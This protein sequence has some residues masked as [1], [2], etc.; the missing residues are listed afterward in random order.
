MVLFRHLSLRE[1]W[2]RHLPTRGGML[3]I[4]VFGACV[5][6]I[7]HFTSRVVQR[8]VAEARGQL[9]GARGGEPAPPKARNQ[10]R[11]RVEPPGT[12]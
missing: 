9:A 10:R 8:A 2:R 1:R 4:A 7:D 11:V 12:T 6:I 3:A 5:L